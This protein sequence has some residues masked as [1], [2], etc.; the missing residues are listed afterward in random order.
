MTESR[1]KAIA[2][3]LLMAVAFVG[4][5]VWK[6]TVFLA[7]QRPKVAVDQLFPPTIGGW[8]QDA[9]GPI[10]LVSPDQAAL[11]A[12]IYSQTLSRTYVD[13]AGRRIMLS[14]AYGG[15]QSDATRAHRPE[16]CYP[17]Q[18]FNVTAS[19][20]RLLD[21][22][23]VNLRTRQLV[24]KQG[25]RTEPITYWIVVGDKAVLGG[26]E[27]KYAQLSYTT[28]GIIPDGMLVRV[29]NIS[30]DA[31]GSFELHRQFLSALV[32]HTRPEHVARIVGVKAASPSVGQVSADTTLAHTGRVGD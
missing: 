24:A 16:V 21:L 28:R 27:Q 20:E 17:A 10:Q 14:V 2:A 31:A 30:A 4:A 11:L 6:P 26:P 7:D 1:S 23:A 29:S 3:A 5:A 32:Q 18:G 15:D 12:K 25:G 22:G 13:A 19:T 9:G 8:R